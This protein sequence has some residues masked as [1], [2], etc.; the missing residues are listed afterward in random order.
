M[1]AQRAQLNFFK[2]EKELSASNMSPKAR[3]R[4]S[5]LAFPRNSVKSVNYG[6]VSP[7]STAQALL[8]N[9]SMSKDENSVIQES[10]FEPQNAIDEVERECF[11][12]ENDSVCPTKNAQERSK[13]LLNFH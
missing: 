2:T 13:D 8:Q 10:I 3:R 12:I 1:K 9:L 4:V 5:K 7:G 6:I 11:R